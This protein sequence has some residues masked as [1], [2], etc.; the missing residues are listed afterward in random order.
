MHALRARRAHTLYTHAR[1]H[2]LRA[3]ATQPCPPCTAPAR[4][5]LDTQLTARRRSCVFRCVAERLAKQALD[6]VHTW[7][8]ATSAST[9][10]PL[11]AS[12][13]GSGRL[14]AALP[15]FGRAALEP[16]QADAS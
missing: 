16:G 6:D 14:A 13:T 12:A 9:G 5:T 1:T 7:V 10:L 15:A 3:N 2:A 4:P 8:R 11:R